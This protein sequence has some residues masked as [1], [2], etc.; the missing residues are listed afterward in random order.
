MESRATTYKAPLVMLL[1]AHLDVRSY[2]IS[3]HKFDDTP[4]ELAR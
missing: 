4:A 2:V 1:V 3:R